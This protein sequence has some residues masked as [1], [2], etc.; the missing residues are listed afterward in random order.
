MLEVE[1]DEESLSTLCSPFFIASAIVLS[2]SLSVNE[3]V[4]VT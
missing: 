3:T 1:M 2:D 4:A